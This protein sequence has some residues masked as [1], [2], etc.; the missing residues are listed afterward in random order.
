[1]QN[2]VLDKV[3]IKPNDLPRERNICAKFHGSLDSSCKTTNINL[4][5]AAE[6][7]GGSSKSVDLSPGN[8]ECLHKIFGSLM[9]Y[10]DT[11][12]DKG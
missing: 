7:S 1:M 12:F 8:H 4:M 5:V 2:K 9:Q 3:K 10:R 6:Q 11:L